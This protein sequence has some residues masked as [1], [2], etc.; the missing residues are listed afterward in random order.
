MCICHEKKLIF[1]HVPKTAGTSII[2]SLGGFDPRFM[3]N[4]PIIEYKKVYQKYWN[5]YKKITSIRD[6][7]NRFVSAYKFARAE[8]SY[9]YS[10][11]E[12]NGLKK[13]PHYDTCKDLDI[14]EYV[15]FLN[16]SKLNFD[17]HLLPQTFFLCNE[18]NVISEIDYYI[19]YE[20]LKEDLEKIGIEKIKKLNSSKIKDKSLIELNDKS[21]KLLSYIYSIDY[22][23]FPFYKK[24]LI[25]T[26]YQYF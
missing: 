15:L 18:N 2:S 24:P 22:Q 1:I 23:N 13:H 3:N 11:T 12:K 17:H 19:K 21:K 9:W 10:S 20:N 7:I 25:S 8:E 6:P 4:P 5:D 26:S 14:N 16:Q